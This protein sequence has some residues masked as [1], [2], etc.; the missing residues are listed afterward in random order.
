MEI[1]FLYPLKGLRLLILILAESALEIIPKDLWIHPAVRRHSKKRKKHPQFLLL[2]R[3]YHHAAMKTL[4]E[5]EKRGRPDI[6]HFALLEALGSPLNKEGLLEVYVHTINDHVIRVKSEAR[7]PKNYNRFVGLM[8][9][10]FELGRTPPHGPILLKLQAKTLPQLLRDISPT[11]VVA[12]SRTGKPRTLEDVVLKLSSGERSVVIIG[13]FPHGHF[14]STT[15]QLADELVCIDEET[16]EA[17]TVTSRVIY[18][19]ERAISLP[20]KRLRL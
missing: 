6:V 20:P 14:S 8:E 18:E 13:G 11:Q 17:W 1:T 10:L 15:M 16:L 3:S 12:F 19:Y 2:D 7:L 4:P 5:N 9:Q